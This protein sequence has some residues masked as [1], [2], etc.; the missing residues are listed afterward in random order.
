MTLIPGEER[1]AEAGGAML[2]GA[3]E[4]ADGIRH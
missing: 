1:R 2:V 3:L 4:A